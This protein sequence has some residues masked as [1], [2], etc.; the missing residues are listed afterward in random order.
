L[1]GGV[2][3]GAGDGEALDAAADAGALL[4]A[5]DDEAGAEADGFDDADVLLLLHAVTVAAMA[6]TDTAANHR[7]GEGMEMLLSD[8]GETRKG[9]SGGPEAQ[10]AGRG[11]AQ[12][13]KILRKTKGL[14]RRLFG[15][16]K[17]LPLQGFRLGNLAPRLLQAPFESPVSRRFSCYMGGLSDVVPQDG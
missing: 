14:R 12:A 2:V 1:G 7:F 3:L 15:A 11:S 4:G 17:C 10:V 8:A 16:L 5:G 13:S 6:N 9:L